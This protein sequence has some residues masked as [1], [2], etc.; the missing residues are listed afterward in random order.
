MQKWLFFLEFN[1]SFSYV[2]G[3]PPEDS[4]VK[5]R[6]IRFVGLPFVFASGGGRRTDVV[7]PEMIR[8]VKV[9]VFSE[10]Q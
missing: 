7:K 6:T 4:V 5:V 3:L 10:V 2:R 1:I 8:F 9:T